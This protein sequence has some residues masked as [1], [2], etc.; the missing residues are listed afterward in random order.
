M[1][2]D[3]ADLRRRFDELRIEEQRQVPRFAMA[4]PR[5][6]WTLRLAAAVLLL[7]IVVIGVALRT[8]RE[9][10]FSP[11]DHAIVQSLD[12]WRAPTDALLAPPGSEIL[13]SLPAIPDL[14]GVTP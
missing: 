5:P 12:A 6:R 8:R 1:I 10:T 4:R 14:Q 11:A 3:E 7:L 2:D 9:T 13:S